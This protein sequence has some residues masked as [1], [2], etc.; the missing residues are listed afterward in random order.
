M[1]KREAERLKKEEEANAAHQA[2]LIEDQKKRTPAYIESLFYKRKETYED[3][4]KK[5]K[6]SGQPKSKLINSKMKAT[7][8]KKKSVL[9]ESNVNNIMQD[10]E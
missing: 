6:E 10:L 9:P 1:E 3:D 5:D 4:D 7:D 8:G 2:K